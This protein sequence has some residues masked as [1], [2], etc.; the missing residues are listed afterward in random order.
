VLRGQLLGIALIGKRQIRQ[1]RT[2]VSGRSG[3]LTVGGGAQGQQYL[4]ER[5]AAWRVASHLDDRDVADIMN[6]TV[7]VDGQ[8]TLRT[9]SSINRTRGLARGAAPRYL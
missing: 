9:G 1:F 6:S 5:S 3:D 7:A 2:S 4:Q 8:L